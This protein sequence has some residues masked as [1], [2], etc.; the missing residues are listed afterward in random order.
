MANGAKLRRMRHGGCTAAVRAFAVLLALLLPAGQVLAALHLHCALEHPLGRVTAHAAG[1]ERHDHFDDH[2]HD[3]DHG[4]RGPHAVSG[5]EAAT[6]H[7]H[8]TG[9]P[10][11]AHARHAAA[12]EP[13]PFG[14]HHHHHNDGA[15]TAHGGC[16]VGASAAALLCEVDGLRVDV[17]AE[18]FDLPVPSGA[19]DPP[20]HEPPPRPQ[21]RAHAPA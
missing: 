8:D 9:E 11:D 18:P 19:Y 3:H 20:F 16:C 6:A 7:Q 4:T 10:S 14:Q 2:D 13:T 12:A 17:R 15:A 1:D 5:A 21:W